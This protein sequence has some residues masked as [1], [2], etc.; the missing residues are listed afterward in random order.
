MYYNILKDKYD[1]SLNYSWDLTLVD[2]TIDPKRLR[3][4]LALIDDS[5]D[6]KFIADLIHET[7][8]IPYSIFKLSLKYSFDKF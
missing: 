1:G 7:R 3:E 5:K 2:R 4:Y 6:R 8:Y